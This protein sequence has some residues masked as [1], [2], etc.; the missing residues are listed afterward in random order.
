MP[1]LLNGIL[2]SSGVN[3]L[4]R[5][6]RLWSKVPVRNNLSRLEGPAR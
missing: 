5:V 3:G 1:A 4:T 6:R 2:R